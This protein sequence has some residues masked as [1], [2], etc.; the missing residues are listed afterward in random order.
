M[1]R[2]KRQS[3]A[4]FRYGIIARV[5][6][7]PTGQSAYFRQLAREELPVPFRGPRRYSEATFKAWL[8]AYRRHGLEG[9][10]PTSRSDRGQSRVIGS[11]LSQIIRTLLAQHPTLSVPQLRELLIAAGHITSRRISEATLRRHINQARLRPPQPS[12]RPR[13]K[14][15]KPQANDLWI[16]DFMHGPRV[17]LLGRRR[18]RPTYLLAAIDDHSR[19]LPLAAF[20]LKEDASSVLAALK[21]AFARHGLPKILYCDN[22]PSFSS[23]LLTLA[24]AR[25]GIALV[26]SRPYD[27]PSR[28]KIERL[29]KTVRGSFLT[30]LPLET[31]TGLDDLNAR[32]QHWLQQHYHRR[33]HRGTGESPL[34]RY[35]RSL[36]RIR[37][38]RLA[39]Q[40]LDLVFYRTLTRKVRKDSTISIGGSFWEVPAPYIG[41]RIQIRHPEGKPQQLYLFEDNQPVAR[42]R[43][44]PLA[45]NAA[46]EP[47]LRFALQDREEDDS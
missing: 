12:P 41:Q 26:H 11:K 23:R 7:A 3:I 9:L 4:I 44:V 15:E 36:S 14:F 29:F 45:D 43:P 42:L 19:F 21:E 17:P 33:L 28:G 30:L 16:L 18:P 1:D 27:S 31:L 5:L 8:R 38:R 10:M 37:H 39:P 47:P 32:F 34:D 2:D 13:K 40:E 46:L 20:F 25:L 24:C 6:H 35:L 22:G